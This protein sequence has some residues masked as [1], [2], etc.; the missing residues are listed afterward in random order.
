VILHDY[1]AGHRNWWTNEPSEPHA[2]A[3]DY[4]LGEAFQLIEDYTD[5]NGLLI[6]ERDSDRVTVNAI[7]KTNKAKAAIA[8]KTKGSKKKPYDPSPGEYWL[9]EPVL[10]R[11]E[12]WPSISEWSAQESKKRGA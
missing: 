1:H 2:T 12:D 6:W 11:G 10:M 9:T 4:A 8:R 3:W 5:D 7:K